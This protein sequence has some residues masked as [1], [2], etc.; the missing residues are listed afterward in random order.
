MF[1]KSIFIK[2]YLKIIEQLWDAS[3][4]DLRHLSIN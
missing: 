4:N 3:E 1:S 2:S